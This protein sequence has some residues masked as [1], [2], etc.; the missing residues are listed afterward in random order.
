MAH[1]SQLHVQD[2]AMVDLFYGITCLILSNGEVAERTSVLVI[3]REERGAT[4]TAMAAGE[5]PTLQHK[6]PGAL[7]GLVPTHG[8][9]KGGG[10]W[11]EWYRQEL[12]PD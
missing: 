9:L 3:S 8:K 5:R 11:F 6:L 2:S 7:D 1:Q 10:R 12:V 4:D